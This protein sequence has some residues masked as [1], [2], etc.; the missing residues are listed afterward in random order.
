MQFDLFE[1]NDFGDLSK[2][3]NIE[4]FKKF[5][6]ENLNVY[7]EL[8]TL[9]H[10]IKAKG[11]RRYSLQTI[12]EVVRWKGSLKTN[13]EEFKLNNNH[14]PFYARLIM[15]REVGLKNFFETRRAIADR[16]PSLK[17]KPGKDI[18]R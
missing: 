14:R 3:P 9:A 4:A 1:N 6:S 18:N 2:H 10:E 16:E 13:D 8:V 11:Y 5:H 12:Y 17:T 7:R 15:K